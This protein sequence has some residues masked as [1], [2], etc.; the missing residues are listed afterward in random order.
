MATKAAVHF[1]NSKIVNDWDPETSLCRE[2][3]H[4]EIHLL[5]SG[6]RPLVNLYGAR[7]LFLGVTARTPS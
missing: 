3:N 7:R 1:W 5:V 4:F 2:L 6:S